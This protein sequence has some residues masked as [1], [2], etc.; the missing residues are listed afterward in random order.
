MEAKFDAHAQHCVT[1]KQENK[2][3]F[4]S[5]DNKLWVIMGGIILNL[6]AAFGFAAYHGFPWENG[7]VEIAQTEGR[8]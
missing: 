4:D 2:S 1:D 6:I 5:I 8:E 3:R 7:R